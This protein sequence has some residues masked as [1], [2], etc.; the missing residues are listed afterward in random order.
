MAKYDVQYACGCE[1]VVNLFGKVADRDRKLE[2]IATKDC[3]KC[4]KAKKNEAAKNDDTPV[5]IVISSTTSNVTG[6]GMRLI[7]VAQG[8]AYKKKEE[9][10]SLG[11]AYSTLTADTGL[12]GF[13]SLSVEKKAWWKSIPITSADLASQEALYAATG[14]SDGKIGAFDARIEIDEIDLRLL[15]EGCKAQNK[16][17]ERKQKI[18]ISPIRKWLAENNKTD[19]WN[20]KLYGSDKYGYR[21]YLDGKE[22]KLPSEI[23]HRQNVWLKIRDEINAEYGYKP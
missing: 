15:A 10:K 3:P 2:W 6:A 11:F 7:A 18:G 22:T 9:L 13:L 23:A 12:L 21:I 20:G 4:A 19:Y 1:G 17:E 14:I 8:G 5:T 16:D